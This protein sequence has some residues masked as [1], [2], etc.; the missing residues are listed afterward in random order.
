MQVFVEPFVMTKGG[1][2]NATL[3]VI[4]LV[5]RYGFEYRDFGI[6]GA[7]GVLMFLVL[8]VFSLIYLRLMKLFRGTET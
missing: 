7:L 2:A 8:V 4:M 6:A 5:Y 1:P 3:T